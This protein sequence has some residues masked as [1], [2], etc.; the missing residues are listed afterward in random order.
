[1][2]LGRVDLSS[3]SEQ[4]C[5]IAAETYRAWASASQV[6]ADSPT[7]DAIVL[8]AVCDSACTADK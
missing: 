4:E 8:D 7:S 5:L 1:M 6:V 2:S 3:L